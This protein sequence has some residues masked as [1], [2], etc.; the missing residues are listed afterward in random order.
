MSLGRCVCTPHAQ[1]GCT[2]SM[3]DT[4]CWCTAMLGQC[5]DVLWTVP[6]PLDWLSLLLLHPDCKPCHDGVYKHGMS[7]FGCWHCHYLQGL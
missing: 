7:C 1:A 2:G 4:S 6:K 5:C 3:F